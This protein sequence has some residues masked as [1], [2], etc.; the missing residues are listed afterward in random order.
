MKIIS[1]NIGLPREVSWQGKIVSTGIFKSPVD[2]SIRLR[3]LNLDGDGQ[4]DLSVHGGVTK[5][6]YA[7]PGEHYDFWRQELTDM[8]LTWGNFGENFTTQGLLEDNVYIGDILR[9][10]SALVRVTD[11]SAVS[12]KF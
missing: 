3:T 1:I 8:E 4:G 12:H 6:V 11:P 5:S 10:G 7:Y 2:G 9:I